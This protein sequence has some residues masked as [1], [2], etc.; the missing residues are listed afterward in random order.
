MNNEPFHILLAEDDEGDRLIFKEALEE[1]EIRPIVSTVNSGV[2]LMEYL[3]TKNLPLPHLIFLDLNMPRKS[4]LECLKEIRSHETLKDIS[5]AIYS[6]S[7]REKDIEEAFLNR[8]N[9][10]I[11]KPNNYNVLKQLLFKAVAATY[12]NQGNSLNRESFFLK[13]K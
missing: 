9:V 3:T 6:T 5:I 4:G 13:I 11:K 7:D 10:Y 8:A 2:E 12:L 1:L